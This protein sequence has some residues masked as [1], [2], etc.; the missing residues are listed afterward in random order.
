[1]LLVLHYCLPY[2][3]NHPPHAAASSLDLS[4]SSDVSASDIRLYEDEAKTIHFNYTLSVTGD[5]NHTLALAICVTVDQSDIARAHVS[6]ASILP[7]SAD[8]SGS[9]NVSV[10]GLLVGRA[11]LHVF[12]V[13]GVSG[14]TCGQPAADDLQELLRVSETSDTREFAWNVSRASSP[15]TSS[16]PSVSPPSSSSTVG[17]HTGRKYEVVVLRQERIIDTIF[18][19]GVVILVVVI[20]IGMGCK[21]DMTVV[22]ATLRRPLAPLTGFGSQFVIMPLTAFA[23]TRCFTLEPGVALGLFAVGCCPGGGA[24]N[25]YC[26]LL[27]GDVSLSITMTFISNL[28][29]IGMVPLWLFTLGRYVSNTVVNVPFENIIYSLLGLVGAVG[30]GVLLQVKLPVW[31]RRAVT[32]SKVTIVVFIVFMCTVGV[33]A[34]L[35]IFRLL[36]GELLAAAALL[37]YT[38][39][40]LGGM[41]ALVLRMSKKH[42]ITIAIE[43]GIQNTG[44]AV[45]LLLLSL[46][47]PESDRNESCTSGAGVDN[48]ALEVAQDDWR[49]EGEGRRSDNSGTGHSRD[50]PVT[51]SQMEYTENQTSV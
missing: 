37:P 3:P 31:A 4:V 33:Y 35:Y 42:V 17:M 12:F 29:A 43:T 23:A 39:F 45:I 11:A 26:F 5:S 10:L 1:M 22:K 44:I 36:R 13:V 15:V 2:H 49:P 25:S 27:G 18:T 7:L 30:V 47:H 16:T 28:A 14:V 38:G 34:N 6:K 19:V 8:T 48:V 21:L 51:I 40:L 41:V 20:N 46:D 50:G 9:F 24:S 32:V